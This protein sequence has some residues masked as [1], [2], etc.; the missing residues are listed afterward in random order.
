MNDKLTDKFYPRLM[1]LGVQTWYMDKIFQ[2]V[3][4][5]TVIYIITS[6]LDTKWVGRAEI[7]YSSLIQTLRTCTGSDYALIQTL[8]PCTGST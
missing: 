6:S 5:A 3:Q 7:S 8:P 1:F 2:S 4:R